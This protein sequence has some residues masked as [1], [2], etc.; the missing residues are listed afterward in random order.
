[1]RRT[2][3][4][5]Q[6][7][8]RNVEG[9]DPF[10]AITTTAPSHLLSPI[11]HIPPAVCIR[12]GVAGRCAAHHYHTPPSHLYI[13][14]YI[15]HIHVPPPASK[16]DCDDGEGGRAACACRRDAS[17]CDQLRMSR[18]LIA[19]LYNWHVAV[20]WGYLSDKKGAPVSRRRH[21][22]AASCAIHT[23]IRARESACR[24]RRGGA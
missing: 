2:P 17:A 10:H 1:M 18:S 23:L 8:G 12:T 9:D 19:V 7:A 24:V 20:L 11:S 21:M 6:E 13:A 14:I 16:K 3:R 5:R 15:W 22:R 4:T